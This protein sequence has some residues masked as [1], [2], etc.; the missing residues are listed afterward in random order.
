[1]D[2]EIYKALLEDLTSILYVLAGIFFIFSLVIRIVHSIKV[3][4]IKDYKAKY[5]YL[6]IY[7]NKIVWY[8]LLSFSIAVFL[9]LNT[10]EKET[11]L[12]SQWWFVIR[13]FITACISTLIGYVGYLILKFYNPGKIQKKLDKWRYMPRI[14]ST[15]NEMKLLSEEEE[16]VYLDEGMQAEENIFSVDYDVWVDEITKEIKIEKYAG[17]LEVLKCGTCTFQTLKLR[18]EEII[19]PATDFEDGE[20]L[21]HYECTYCSSKRTTKHKIGKLLKSEKD[22]KLPQDYV[23][24]GSRK[25]KSIMIEI[26][27]N[28]GEKSEFYFQSKEDAA[29]FLEE[30]EYDKNPVE[31]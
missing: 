8:S 20:L 16:D 9:I 10:F 7:E 24:K 25:V 31:V 12:I 1:M 17:Y 13:M 26:I 19:K 4:T 28:K 5:D 22:F 3:A 30:F 29:R 15:G 18:E 23:L 6:R 21:K 14:S 27:S 11:V 2:N